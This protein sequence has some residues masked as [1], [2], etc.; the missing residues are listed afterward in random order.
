MADPHYSPPRRQGNVTFYDSVTT[1]HFTSR[2]SVEVRDAD[3]SNLKLTAT[4]GVELS[5][6]V[7]IKGGGVALNKIKVS[8][9]GLDTMPRQFVTIV[10]TLSVDDAGLFMQKMFPRESSG[11]CLAEFPRMRMWKISGKVVE[12]STTKASFF[13]I[14]RFRSR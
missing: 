13:P 1:R 4:P 12:A 3:V 6:R 9:R 11:W 5:G 14:R 2:T 7:V 8:L 10:G